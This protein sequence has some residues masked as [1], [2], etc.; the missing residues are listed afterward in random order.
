MQQRGALPCLQR[1]QDLHP[2]WY[3][4]RGKDFNVWMNEGDMIAR[5]DTV[6]KAVG[7][8]SDFA[9]FMTKEFEWGVD[10][11]S[12]RVGRILDLD[13]Y[14]ELSIRHAREDDT[15]HIEDPFDI[16]RN[17]SCVFGPYAN[18]KLWHCLKELASGAQHPDELR[19]PDA[20][21]H[22]TAHLRPE[23]SDAA[24]PRSNFPPA[25]SPAEK[26]LSAL[27]WL[28]QGMRLKIE[29]ASDAMGRDVMQKRAAEALEFV[30]EC[31]LI[32]QLSKFHSDMNYWHQPHQIATTEE[33]F[34]RKATTP[35]VP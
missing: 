9:Q 29:E 19:P 24:K 25:N 10:V 18:R 32:V 1:D 26:P 7:T 28:E 21:I 33:S 2:E 14:P 3:R 15:L 27:D 17:L 13:A 30:V 22:R 20:E 23:R 6:G 11:V 12:V 8:L 34:H 16:S 31:D 35:A 5:G 4:E